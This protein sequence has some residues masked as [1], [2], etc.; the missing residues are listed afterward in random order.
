MRSLFASLIVLCTAVP[1]LAQPV[2]PAPEQ[3]PKEQQ[4]LPAVAPK[5]WTLEDIQALLDRGLA[6]FQYGPFE[7]VFHS[8]IQMWG[9]W[10]G[11]KGPEQN[12]LTEGD[13]LQD[14]GF[15]L[16]RV[17]FGIEG[18]I[19]QPLTYSVELDI[20]DE[21]KSGGP[22]YSAWIDYS[23]CHWFGATLGFQKFP[24]VR[25]EMNS[26]ATLAHLDRAVG[27]DAMSPEHSL[28]IA[29]HTD[30]WKD[31][32]RITLGLFNGQQRTASFFTGYQ[33]VS[34]SQGNLLSDS[35]SYVARLD[36]EPL[37]KLGDG[38]PDLF[39]VPSFRLG[40]G[41]AFLYNNG[42]SSN[43]TGATGYI[44]MKA[45]GFH[46]LG[47]AIWDDTKPKSDSTLPPAD[48]FAGQTKRFVAHTTVGYVLMRNLL[49]L[50]A[51]VEYINDNTAIHDSGDQ[52]IYAGTLTYY[53]IGHYLKVQAE[54]G[55]RQWLGGPGSAENHQY[56]LGSVQMYF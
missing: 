37:A 48:N 9:G 20:F 14:S 18:H 5:A 30:P 41:G 51:R 24:F 36:L 52:M 17:R 55:F 44:Q 50:A 42:P 2:E 21:G 4:P 16:R 29:L 39:K 25:T 40:L 7:A 27:A 8:R 47:E 32:L 13:K 56:M 46:L 28:G 53:A 43:T 10:A 54:Y 12:L 34:V 49:G 26:S 23:P 15:R 1:A 33:P 38:E 6:K 3:G 22:L 31:H 11:F 45:W 19:F 35:L